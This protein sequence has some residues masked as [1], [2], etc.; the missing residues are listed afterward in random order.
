MVWRCSQ[1]SCQFLQAEEMTGVIEFTVIR[2]QGFDDIR[3]GHIIRLDQMPVLC[4]KKGV[5]FA[6]AAIVVFSGPVNGNIAEHDDDA[7]GGG[8][9]VPA[10]GLAVLQEGGL[11]PCITE[12]VAG[13]GHFGE[14]DDIRPFFAGL[15]DQRK[16]PGCVFIRVSG[17]DFHLSHGDIQQN[18]ALPFT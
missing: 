3:I 17:K 14:N 6:H 12:K 18:Q 10:K 2:H 4:S 8:D 7:M 11:F 16:D 15:F 5:V 9:D 13:N 1:L